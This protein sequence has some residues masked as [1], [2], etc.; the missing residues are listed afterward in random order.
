MR[1]VGVIPARYRASRFP[2]K[3]LAPI[4]GMPMIQRVWLGA[5]SAKSLARVIVATDDE[6]IADACR[7][8]GAEV[9][10]TRADH[11]SGTDRA[12]EVIARVDCDAV[13]NV[14]GDEPLIAGF[15]ID[16]VVAALGE[17]PEAPMATLAHAAEPDALG[18][19]NR[20]KVV[21]DRRGRALYFSR[22]AI[23]YPR[24]GEPRCWQHVGLYAYR[25]DFLLR[26]PALAP[27]PAERA[28]GLEQLRALEHGYPI[29]CAVIEGWTSA[30]VDVPED[31]ARV[32]ALL[33]GRG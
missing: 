33:A 1:A 12:A 15:A 4:A 23:P 26:F 28:E 31:V 10:I 9:A 11:E 5:R 19:P 14:Q 13:V 21:L 3:P 7:S 20:V 25:R 16:A 8:F 2:G 6:R 27:T 30:A 22:S 17:D 24:V 29:R 18:D 32:E